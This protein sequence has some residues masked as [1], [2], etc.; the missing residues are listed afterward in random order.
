MASSKSF[1]K[2]NSQYEPGGGGR[3]LDRLDSMRGGSASDFMGEDIL[4]P[5]NNVR[6]NLNRIK[7][8]VT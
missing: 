6:Y 4:G 1:I 8:F 2:L 3:K 5:L 7:F